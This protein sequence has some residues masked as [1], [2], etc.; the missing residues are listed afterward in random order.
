MIE[1]MESLLINA[2][3][4]VTLMRLGFLAFVVGAFVDG[5]L[6]NLPVTFDP[7]AW[8]FGNS[9]F[10]LGSVLALA[11]WA[12]HTSIGGRKLW[13]QDLFT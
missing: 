13:N 6:Y 11:A 2:I 8:Y 9:A 1:G 5:V 3:I 7:S 12:F 4:A 10:M